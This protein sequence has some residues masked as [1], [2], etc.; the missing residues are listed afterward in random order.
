MSERL[1][2]LILESDAIVGGDLSDTL[3]RRGYSVL[4]LADN[5]ERALS[6]MGERQPDLMLID[7][8]M[9]SRDN[10]IEAA[11]QLRE[12]CA[13]PVVFMTGFSSE[14]S[15]D[16]AKAVRPAVFL[17]KPFSAWELQA[18]VEGAMALAPQ[19]QDEDERGDRFLNTLKSLNE[20]VIASDLQGRI[21]FFNSAAEELTACSGADAISRPLSEVVQV[22][23]CEREGGGEDSG[24]QGGAGRLLILTDAGGGEIKIIE[25]SSPLRDEQGEVIGLLTL[26]RQWQEGVVERQEGEG[27]EKAPYVPF[28]ELFDYTD[29]GGR[30]E[31]EQ[32]GSTEKKGEERESGRHLIEGITDP[33]ITLDEDE[34]VSYANPEAGA[35]LSNGMGVLIGQHFRSLFSAAAG[36]LCAE[37]LKQVRE[38]GRRLCFELHDEKSERWFELNVYPRGKGWLI[39]LRDA[40]AR[41]QE[42]LLQLR[43][44]RLEGLSLLARGFTH[45]FNNLLTVLIGNLSLIQ[46]R[47]LEDKA[48]QSEVAASSLAADQARRL[49]QQLMTFT[50]GGVPILTETKVARVLRR[51]LEE[52]RKSHAKIRYQLICNDPSLRVR[53]DPEQIA[54]LLENLVKNA[55]EAMPA[56]GRLDAVCEL[57]MEPPPQ[58][59]AGGGDGDDEVESYVVIKIIDSGHGMDEETSSRVFEPYFTT[60]QED[61]ASGIGLTVCESIAKAHLGHLHL[62]SKPGEGTQVS[63]YLPLELSADTSGDDDGDDEG[64]L[65]ADEVPVIYSD[66]EPVKAGARRILILE[67][68]NLIRQLIVRCLSKQGYEVVES[69]DGEQTVRLYQEAM[70]LGKPFDLVLSDLTIEGGV[71][72]VEMMKSLRE[73]DPEVRAIVSSGYSDA[74]AMAQ[75]QDFGF[76]A[77]LPKPYPP[78]DLIRVVAEALHA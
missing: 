27:G 21:T 7:L 11:K 58:S 8:R 37:K 39:L 67:D 41:K 47:Y 13:A 6:L 18:A 73:I 48:F 34:V 66:A 3:T 52:H 75:P 54:L 31:I 16:R 25:R 20:A 38:N 1:Q 42:S 32:I 30:E 12:K 78:Q 46:D 65:I 76:I 77:V 70:E 10:G 29:E 19:L 69:V 40:S 22:R 68:E 9:G 33:L 49:V 35:C 56:G 24:R 2:I 64:E 55:E 43:A 28:C 57:S 60:R 61:N 44:H 53:I 62:V 26:F 71:G 17:R 50:K 23:D 4:G 36:E 14:E 45:D 5:V 51:V 72:G 59:G 74:P 15:F 63:L